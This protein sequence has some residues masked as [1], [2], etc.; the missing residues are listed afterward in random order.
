VG[1]ELL[2]HYTERLGLRLNREKTRRL[3]L[4]VGNSVDF[5]GFRFHCVRS[6]QSG[7]RLMLVYPSQRSQERFR[8]TV[9]K[10]VHHSIPLRVKEQVEN[11][12]RYLRGWMGYF[13]L[14]HG[15]VTFRKLARFVNLRVRH[16]I[17]RRRGRRGYGWGKVTSQYIYGQLG[18][19]YD[20]HVAPLSP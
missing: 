9:R 8:A 10:Y 18:L 3:R 11:L 20:Y 4:N 2:N 19:F 6:R 14:G 16:V 1:I 13:R 15:S 5:L 7:T 17:W 12:N